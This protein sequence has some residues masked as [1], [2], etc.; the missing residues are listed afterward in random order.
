MVQMVVDLVVLLLV[1]HVGNDDS[2]D[3]SRKDVGRVV[4]VVRNPGGRDEDGA[5]RGQA[6]HEE[7]PGVSVL[8]KGVQEVDQEEGEVPH[9]GEGHG[10][11]AGGK[12]APALG[13]HSRVS[14]AVRVAW[15]D[16][17][18]GVGNVSVEAPRHKVRPRPAD[19]QLQKAGQRVG[20]PEGHEEP[21]QGVVQLAGGRPLDD[22]Q[23]AR[24][25]EARE[26][27]AGRQQRPR[28]EGVRPQ[29]VRVRP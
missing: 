22:F 4:P 13:D 23:A 10:G 7:L 9:A 21:Q 2:K 3:G 1:R 20:E 5:A 6:G 8:V 14:C 28:R 16:P 25:H 24:D 29:R 15:P 11:V 12:G 17:R 19:H 18:H 27:D 26:E